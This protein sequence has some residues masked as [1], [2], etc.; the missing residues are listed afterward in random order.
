MYCETDGNYPNKI[1]DLERDFG[2]GGFCGQ[3]V[4]H[5]HMYGADIGTV[6]LEQST[7]GNSWNSLWSKSGN[8]GDTWLQATVAVGS[9]QTHLRFKC[10]PNSHEG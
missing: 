2:T 10:V 8:K 1:F 6:V 4:F 7:N 9:T 5:Y 3:I